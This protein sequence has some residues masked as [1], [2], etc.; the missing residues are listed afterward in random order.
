[1]TQS[2]A[3]AV[4][5]LV[6]DARHRQALA[7]VR[8]L[9]ADGLTPA[10]M[11]SG[12]TGAPA[13]VSRWCHLALTAPDLETNPDAYVD[14]VLEA[15]ATYRPRVLMP[16]HDAS[17]SALRTRRGDLEQVVRL[18][19]AGDAA[20]EAAT[21]KALTLAAAEELDVRIPRGMVIRDAA[22]A[23]AALDAVGLP[24]VVKPLRAWSEGDGTGRH[25]RPI[26][27]FDRAVAADMLGELLNTGTGAAIQEWL[28][29]DR[30]AV[31][32][33]YARGRFWARFASR[34]LRAQPPIG[35]DSIVRESIPLPHDTTR[36][37]ERM[38]EHLGLEGYSE[39]EFRRDAEGRA[40][41]MEINARLSGNVGLSLRAGVPF[42]RL[43]YDWACDR[44]L[45]PIDD[46][47][48]GV[49]MRWLGGDLSW[50]RTVLADPSHPDVPSRAVAIR[51]FLA[52]F[53]R[54]SG[55]DYFDWRDLRPAVKAAAGRSQ[56]V[57]RRVLRR[58]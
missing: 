1:V 21:D 53:T 31:A 8:Q 10:V 42:P 7:A 52:D 33:I 41:L 17:I 22:E 18:A 23:E 51:T 2:G 30:E 26:V 15:C 24:V 43:L 57:G 56:R 32:L 25:V 36:D 45:R 48:T 4:H 9:G 38:V 27:T 12:Q 58:R 6:T 34:T 3:T 35:G 13:A 19:L 40:A 54:R 20:V 16:A 39:V 46:Y 5:V 29:G 14:T 28:P 50:L 11:V 44:P 47:R 49:R 37:A 55:Y